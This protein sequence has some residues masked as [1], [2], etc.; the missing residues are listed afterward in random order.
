MKTL[1]SVGVILLMLSLLALAIAGFRP[2]FYV[3]V[4]VIVF[5]LLFN[6]GTPRRARNK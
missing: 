3:I 4:V 6:V 5:V 1:A 2:A